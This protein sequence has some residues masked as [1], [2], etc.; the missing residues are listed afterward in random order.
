MQDYRDLFVWQKVMETVKAIYSIVKKLPKERLKSSII[1]T[2]EIVDVVI[3]AQ[4]NKVITSDK[5][6]DGNEQLKTNTALQMHDSSVEFRT[7]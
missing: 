7:V 1:M 5:L 6:F 4:P 3:A 2:T